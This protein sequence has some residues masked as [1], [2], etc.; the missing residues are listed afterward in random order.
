M[1]IMLS[2]PASGILYAQLEVNDLERDF[3][4]PPFEAKP[5]TW[6]H[7]TG[8]NI[9]IEG[10][11][12]DLEWMKRVGIAGFQ[13]A[14]VSFGMGQTI[15]HK[16]MFGSAEWL[17][18]VKHTA[19]EAVR[20]DLEM[21][22]FS[23]AG[24]SLAG[25]PWVKPEQAMKKLVWSEMKIEGPQ[26]FSGKLPHPP[27]VNGPIRNMTNGNRFNSDPNRYG[28]QAVIAYPTPVDELTYK[29]IIPVITVNGKVIR[30]DALI[31]DDLNSGISLPVDETTRK[32]VIDFTYPVPVPMRALTIASRQGI[33]FGSFTVCTDDEHFKIVTT[34]PGPQLY[35]GGKVRTFSFPEQQSKHFRLEIN[36][37]PFKP[38]QVLHQPPP[39]T[40]ADS[41]ML[42]EA[43][44]HTGARVNC[45]EDKAGFSHLFDYASVHSPDVPAS[46]CINPH[47]IIDL[48]DRMDND[49][50]ITWKVPEGNWT[51]LRTG[52]SLTGAKNRPAMPGGLGYEVD[53]LSKEYVLDY[54]KNYIEPLKKKLGPLVGERLQYLMLDSW[55]AGMQNWTDRMAEEFMKRR[56]YD[57]LP[58]MPVL[59]GRIVENAEVSDRFLW[60][61]RRTLAD[62]FAENFYGT[63]SEYMHQNNMKT[64]GEASGVSLEILEDA[65]LC[66]KYVDIPMGEFWVSDL[67]PSAMYHVDVRGAA[68]A[69]HIYGK[70]YV[71]AEALTGGNYE[72]PARLKK[73]CD[74]WFTQ[75]V[76]RIVFHT[77]AHQPLDTKPGNTMV[78]THIHRN[79]TWAE[80]A[81]PFMTYIARNSYML[82]QGLFVAD[83]AYLLNEGAP[84][85]MP[86][87]GAG[88]EAEPPTGYDYD[89]VNT[90]VLLNRMSVSSNGRIVLPDG[91]S[92]GILVLPCTSEM[93]LR[94]L[95]KINEMVKAGATV[96]GPR[97]GKMPGLEGDPGSENEW[98]TLVNELWGDLD[99]I[100]RTIRY[101]NKGMVVWGESVYGILQRLGVEKDV[102]FSK[103]LSTKISWIHRCLNET[104]FYFIS[105]QSDTIQQVDFN[106]RITDK[107]V[108]LWY[109]GEG[110][111]ADVSYLIKNNRTIVPVRLESNEA[112]FV[113]FRKKTKEQIRTIPTPTETVVTEIN[114]SWKVHFPAGSGAP[115]T[116]D[117]PTLISWTEHADSGIR[118][119]SGTASYANSIK[120]QANQL[121]SGGAIWLD[122]G[123]VKDIA[124]VFINGNKVEILWKIPYK[125]NITKYLKPGMNQ[126]RIDVTNQ[127]T[128]RL[129]G[130]QFAPDG[131][132]VLSS[133]IPSFMGKLKPV[134][135]GLMGPVKIMHVSR[136]SNH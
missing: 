32:I 21:A 63:V 123:N 56:G 89:Y 42:T 126:V 24:W 34:L 95:D 131:E 33:P 38:S 1:L 98:E 108:E 17:D 84:S 30:P 129:A 58:Y 122:L 119:F 19:E 44:L 39:A 115:E 64:Y 26:T 136:K 51:L 18:A 7:W 46:A 134:E 6:W 20:L 31:D 8:G 99:G 54:L 117:F 92:Y 100:S 109:P 60:D 2:I 35:R 97:P 88:P 94:T 15:D 85:T 37:L 132:K 5:R 40:L 93:T 120:I 9:T 96:I 71:A 70:Q 53:K 69:A 11:T 74:Y 106:F 57:L 81:S 86:F 80:Q 48:T 4:N 55:E 135:S 124:E 65:L 118:Y 75:G 59:T 130:D 101:V 133:F 10:I 13:L 27:M 25:G 28:D 50:N 79:I 114:N 52:Y 87:W 14:D 112:V 113:V 105:N 43:I 12:R 110:R 36:G 49:G 45:W 90:D 29:D 16:V 77:S 111:I 121:K 61:F 116:P 82:Q 68:S 66:K 23:S 22:L 127:W 3:I 76:N 107:Q 104:D 67:H 72:A 103:G 125:T 73:I 62:L 41:F 83:I 47:R 78:G 102:E 128:N 91:M